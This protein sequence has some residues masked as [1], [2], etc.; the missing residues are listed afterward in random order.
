MKY[1]VA[2][3]LVI[4]LVRIDFFLGQ[5]ERLAQ[6]FTPV[7]PE[8][9]ASIEQTDRQLIP[10]SQDQNLKQTPKEVFLSLLSNFRVSPDKAIREKALE[11]FKAH[12]TMFSKTLDTELEA[13]I[14]RWQELLHNNE[15]E[16]VPFLITLL[17]ILQGENL[18]MVKRFF[19]LWIDIDL[20]NFIAAYSG[21]KDSNC[22]IITTFG[23]NI[24]ED[25][26]LNEYYEREDALKAFLERPNLDPAQK[27]LAS[28]C[29]LVLGLTIS[30]STPA[31]PVDT[32]GS[33]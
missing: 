25:E 29:L 32:E 17:N 9:E 1:I 12:P 19:S 5:L 26:K 20:A 33:P 15:P 13:Q 18:D 16:V 3:A 30:K 8:I 6:R 7:P 27:A 31:A 28:N 14:F 22:L 23:H 21:T 2:L 24:P 11:V 10:V 4:F